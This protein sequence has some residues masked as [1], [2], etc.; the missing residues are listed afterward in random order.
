MDVFDRLTSIVDAA[1][2]GTIAIFANTYKLTR[3]R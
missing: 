1:P 3:I 2:A